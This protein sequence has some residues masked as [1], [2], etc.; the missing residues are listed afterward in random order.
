MIYHINLFRSQNEFASVPV[1]EKVEANSPM[2]F[3]VCA[4]IYIF[5]VLCNLCRTRIQ[6]TGKNHLTPTLQFGWWFLSSLLELELA[7]ITFLKRYFI[8]IEFQIWFQDLEKVLNLAKM[9]PRYWKS[10]EI[11]NGKNIRSVWVKRS[12]IALIDLNCLL[13][14]IFI[15]WTYKQATCITN[16]SL[17]HQMMI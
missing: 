8:S 12:V 11:P 2:I 9:S 7:F 15:E 3:L 17:V 10:M 6:E 16:R 4:N 13:S 1:F 5:T 14:K